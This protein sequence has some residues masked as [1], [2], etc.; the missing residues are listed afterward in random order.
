MNS[1]LI[2]FTTQDGVASV[3]MALSRA[4][5]SYSEVKQLSTDIE[6]I[7]PAFAGKNVHVG[8]WNI[9]ENEGK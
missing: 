8:S 1:Y 7:F 5:Q 6:R 4:P 2:T 9:L 3:V